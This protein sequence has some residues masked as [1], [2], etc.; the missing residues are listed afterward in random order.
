ML[1]SPNPICS[2]IIKITATPSIAW[3]Y[4]YLNQNYSPQNQEYC[5]LLGAGG[6]LFTIGGRFGSLLITRTRLDN[7]GDP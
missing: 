2:G 3:Y 1:G 5:D 4:Y 7:N 6:A